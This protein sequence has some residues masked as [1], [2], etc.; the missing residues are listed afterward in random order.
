MS[1]INQLFNLTRKKHLGFE[2]IS[3]LFCQ[4][5]KQLTGHLDVFLIMLHVS[6]V[7]H[8]NNALPHI[9]NLFEMVSTHCFYSSTIINLL[10]ANDL[11]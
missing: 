2:D 4:M 5:K 11:V 3:F 9:R 10:R 7:S 8:C 1:Y 6:F